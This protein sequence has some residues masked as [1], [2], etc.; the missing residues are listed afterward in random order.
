MAK[1][2]SKTGIITGHEVDVWHVTQSIDAFTGVE[3]YDIT[4]SGSFTLTGSLKLDGTLIG[5]TTGTSSYTDYA[6]YTLFAATAT[7]ANTASYNDTDY[8]K[9]Q[10]YH[11]PVNLSDSTTYNIGAGE[12]PSSQN[13]GISLPIDTTLTSVN[14]MVVTEKT[15]SGEQ[16]AWGL[17]TLNQGLITTLERTTYDKRNANF[18]T[19]LGYDVD[20]NDPIYFRFDTPPWGTKPFQTSHTVVLTCKP[21]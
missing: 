10:F 5:E 12:T 16:A 17:Y 15:G 6:D 19:G 13:V 14:V 20:K 1:V 11:Y 9:I 2:L 18:P 4:I 3:A 8:F 7:T 21:R